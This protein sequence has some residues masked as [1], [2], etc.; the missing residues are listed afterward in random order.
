MSRAAALAA[1]AGASATPTVV[2]CTLAG[3]CRR[4]VTLEAH[5]APARRSSLHPVEVVEGSLGG[6][7]CRVKAHAGDHLYLNEGNGRHLLLPAA[8][9]IYTNWSRTLFLQVP[10]PTIPATGIRLLSPAAVG[11]GEERKPGDGRLGLVAGCPEVD[12]RE[13]G[14]VPRRGTRRAA[15]VRQQ[16]PSGCRDRR[17]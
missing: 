13:G 3:A 14:G 5:T 1:E 12:R 4:P 8:T 15:A 6:F 16:R 17:G 11:H 7:H 10:E 2:T 9:I